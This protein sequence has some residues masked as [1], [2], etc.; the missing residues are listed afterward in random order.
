MTTWIKKN[1]LLSFFFISFTLFW[2]PGLIQSF[3]NIDSILL[4]A[5][6]FLGPSSPAIAFLIT[7]NII[8]DKVDDYPI[9]KKRIAFFLSW[10]IS[11]VIIFIVVFFVHR[12]NTSLENS[13]YL[14]ITPIII[15]L[16]MGLIPASIIASAHSNKPSIRKSLAST[17][18]PTGRPIIYIAA[19]IFP[20]IIGFSTFL[21]E[22][23][24][25]FLWMPDLETISGLSVQ[26]GDSI[27]F[28]LFVIF[29]EVGWTGFALPHLQKKFSP[30]VASVILGFVCVIW[31]LPNQIISTPVTNMSQISYW[32]IYLI[33]G[34]FFYICIR[35]IIT[36]LYKKTEG[37]I[38]PAIL[39]MGSI[40]IFPSGPGWLAIAY[41]IVAILLVIQGKMWRKNFGES[42]NFLTC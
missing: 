28:L 13:L 14:F 16:S 25:F 1:P 37:S 31:S 38:I 26:I 42:K 17:I 18:H 32:G 22:P 34:S 15:S 27:R 35:I 10:L 3:S 24:S 21:I 33:F 19:F 36:W 12:P 29:E 11:T 9:R 2:V 6:N 20:M 39:F 23:K 40:N 7:A 30:F 5:V 41:I 4:A 8:A